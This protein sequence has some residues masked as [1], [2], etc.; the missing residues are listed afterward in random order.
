MDVGGREQ[1]VRSVIFC[2]RVL[3]KAT[4]P[5]LARG[6]SD[7]GMDDRMGLTGDGTGLGSCV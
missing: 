4:P 2:S 7:V 3:S 5:L 1:R 6:V